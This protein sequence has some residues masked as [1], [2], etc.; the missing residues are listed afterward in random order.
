MKFTNKQEKFID[1]YLIDLN[2]TQSAIRAGYSTK[3]AQEIG[4]ENLS[5]PMIKNEIDKRLAERSRRTGI[6]QD[7]IINELSKIALSNIKDFAKWSDNGVEFID[8][9]GISNDDL[10]CISEISELEVE[11]PQG[12]IRRTKKLKLYDK[13]SALEKLGKHLGMFT[14]RLEFVGAVGVTIIDDLK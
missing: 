11:T 8:S 7:R 5:K 3:T 13:I 10:C 6:N 14:N 2:A 12:G 1:E 4:S 9:E